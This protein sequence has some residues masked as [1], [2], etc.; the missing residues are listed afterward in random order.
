V[1]NNLIRFHARIS[2]H[3]Q[4]LLLLDLETIGHR[5]FD[6]RH[7]F[8]QRVRDLALSY[9]SHVPAASGNVIDQQLRTFGVQRGDTG[10]QLAVSAGS[11]AAAVS[12]T[13]GISTG[14]G[15]PY[16]NRNR[17]RASD[18]VATGRTDLSGDGLVLLQ[19][20]QSISNDM[21]RLTRVETKN[22]YI[23]VQRR[24][25]V[26]P[27]GFEDGSAGFL[28]SLSAGG[29]SGDSSV[30]PADNDGSRP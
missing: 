28:S 5:R 4:C 8:Q 1:V 30:P 27:G 14:E 12:G 7:N 20:A 17:N 13:F 22:L 18:T 11:E 29:G 23:A 25:P 15:V 10:G 26:I 19:L 3:D 2:E 24:I 6:F 21:Q 9:L 16:G